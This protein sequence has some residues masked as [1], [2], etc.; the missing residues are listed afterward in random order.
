[1]Q[2]FLDNQ[3]AALFQGTNWTSDWSSASSQTLT[4][5][6]A[7]NQ[8][9]DTSVSANEPAFQ[10]LA[11]AYTMVADLG[12]QNLSPGA[13]QALVAT[14]QKVL[15]SG[16]S[17]LTDVQAGIGVAQSSLTDAS[18]QMSLQMN[19][20]S[21]QISNLEGINTYDVSTRVTELQTQIETSYSLTSQLTQL[22]LVKFL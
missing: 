20:L 13:Y 12:G 7:P 4:S 14:A 21:T 3:F 2:S 22:S 11:Q 16:I 9:A 17:K 10:Q 19:I 1:M 6:I 18:S 8:A 5:Q 15:T